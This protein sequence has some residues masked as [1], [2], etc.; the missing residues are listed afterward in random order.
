MRVPWPQLVCL[1]HGSSTVIRCM[2]FVI[3]SRRHGMGLQY[4]VDWEGYGPVE[5]SWLNTSW[6]LR[7]FWS[8]NFNTQSSRR[9]TPG[10]RPFPV[11]GEGSSP[12]GPKMSVSQLEDARSSLQARSPPGHGSSRPL[13]Q[14]GCHCYMFQTYFSKL[15]RGCKSIQPLDPHCCRA[16]SQLPVQV[17]EP[18]S[19]CTCI[20]TLK[21][22][23]FESQ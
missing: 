5:R 12:K 14:S 7:W 13:A 19:F 17:R 10:G 11:L 3:R 16:S 2:R 9:V 8:S 4:L 22:L 21:T 18:D 6:T 15:T 23:F 1:L 20:I